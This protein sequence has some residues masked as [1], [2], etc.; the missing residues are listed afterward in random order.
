MSTFIVGPR[1]EYGL[2]AEQAD[3]VALTAEAAPESTPL[4]VEVGFESYLAECH[5]GVQHAVP[6]GWTVVSTYQASTDDSAEMKSVVVKDLDILTPQECI[7]HAREVR[8]GRLKEIRSLFDL[9][10]FK[11]MLRH[12]ARNRLDA[13]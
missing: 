2:A 13:R 8:A 1:V 3:L 9:G 4:S 11:R 12:L 5:A 10:C 6:E 7:T